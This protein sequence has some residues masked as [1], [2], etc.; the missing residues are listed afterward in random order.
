MSLDAYSKNMKPISSYPL[1]TTENYGQLL[2]FARINKKQ[3]LEAITDTTRSDIAV[4][5][6]L[7][8]IEFSIRPLIPLIYR[9]AIESDVFNKLDSK[10]QVFLRQHT[11]D[12]VGK[13]LLNQQWLKT[14][15]ESFNENNIPIILLKAAA[16]ARN[17]YPADAPRP[18][19]DLDFLVKEKDFNKACEVLGDTMNPIVM[20]QARLATHNS[21]FERMFVPK[22]NTTPVVEIHRGLTNPYI[23][24]ICENHLWSASRKHPAYDNEGVRI[25]SI[26]HTLLHLAVHAFR[27]MDFCNHNL[28]D[29]HELISQHGVDAEELTNEAIDWGGRKILYYLLDNAKNVMETP[30][31]NSL[32]SKLEPGRLQKRIHRKLL[33]SSSQPKIEI[34]FGDRAR[35]LASQLLLPNRLRS[36]IKF[37]V[38]YAATRIRDFASR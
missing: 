29:V 12:L 14:T 27:D 22:D 23:F 19:V 16:F 4:L 18:G 6:A 36:A 37:Q 25:L 35:Q 28:L 24:T 15:F 3:V 17:I 34:T 32:L 20:S 11:L 2:R 38:H 9:N 1:T 7:P 13:E 5:N 8:T 21:L 30:I 26:E 10:T 31:E 33:Q